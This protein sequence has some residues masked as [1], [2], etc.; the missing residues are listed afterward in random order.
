MVVVQRVPVAS[1]VIIAQWSA[2]V[3]PYISFVEAC[4]DTH[5][6]PAN[7]SHFVQATATNDAASNGE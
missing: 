1:R 4:N 6:W 3:Y 5:R 7:V 2:R